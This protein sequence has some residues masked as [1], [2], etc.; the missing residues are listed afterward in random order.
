[1]YMF[2]FIY[3][4]THGHLVCVW[5]DSVTDGFTDTS[6]PSLLLFLSGVLVKCYFILMYWNESKMTKRNLLT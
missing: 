1:M 2:F 3:M 6:T 5:S 4:Y